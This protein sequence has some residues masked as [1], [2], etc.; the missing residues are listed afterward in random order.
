LVLQKISEIYFIKFAAFCAFTAVLT[1]LIIHSGYFD[2][3][4]LTM[5]ENVALFKNS[6]YHLGR[7]IIIIHC[8]L[9]LVSVWAIFLVQY[10]K[11]LGL[12]G[13]GFVFY[14]LFSFTEIFRQFME[15]FYL[16]GLRERYFMSDNFE[17]Q[18]HL[19]AD[20]QNFGLFAYS[21][22]GL[23]ILMFAL[24]NVC[25]GLSFL[26]GFKWEK[27]LGISLVLWGVLGLISLGN[28]FWTIKS[29]EKGSGIILIA[30]QPIIR[31]GIG[32]WLLM[33]VISNNFSENKKALE[34]IN[35][36]S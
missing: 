9:V 17:V 24:G 34:E 18:G 21:F 2:F 31:F 33:A 7:W 12:V 1:T 16:N 35:S 30:I 26:K 15:L 10:K 27:A 19:M 36:A 5:E 28:E 22:Y 13:L 14:L 29:I 4:G 32:Y 3:G 23:F 25:Y 6:K 8:L 20:I 11:S